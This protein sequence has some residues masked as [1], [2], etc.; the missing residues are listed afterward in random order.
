MNFANIR[1]QYGATKIK[2]FQ[3]LWED[4][5]VLIDMPKIKKSI[6]FEIEDK[7]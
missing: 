3:L 7:Q 6:M 1:G 2:Y 4:G 5:G